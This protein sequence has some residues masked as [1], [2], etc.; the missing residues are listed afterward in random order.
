MA[1]KA[2][3]DGGTASESW[4]TLRSCATLRTPERVLLCRPSVLV[5][6]GMTTGFEGAAGDIAVNF[7]ACVLEVRLV[8]GLDSPCRVPGCLIWFDVT[9]RPPCADE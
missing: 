9:C 7:G 4:G 3:T 6:V 1:R 8:V 2:A 5:R